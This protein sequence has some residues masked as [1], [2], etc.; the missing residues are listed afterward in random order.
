MQVVTK[1]VVLQV[2]IPQATVCSG[3]R[4]GDVVVDP[5]RQ[6]WS[7]AAG[8]DNREGVWHKQ[9]RSG[10][11]S[12]HRDGLRLL[13]VPSEIP[14]VPEGDGDRPGNFSWVYRFRKSFFLR[15]RTE[16]GGLLFHEHLVILG[17]LE[18]ALFE[19]LTEVVQF[20]IVVV[21]GGA[22]GLILAGESRNGLPGRNHNK[23]TEQEEG[24]K[25]CPGKQ[26]QTNQ[27]SF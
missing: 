1:I 12:I 20:R 15:L 4:R 3:S 19:R 26:R 5:E 2:G 22:G 8:G 21:T 16:H 6:V 7:E 24:N 17:E 10:Y 18:S 14:F 9:V 23:Q 27:F 11:I 13:R 25:H